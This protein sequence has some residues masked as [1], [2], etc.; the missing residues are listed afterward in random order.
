[1]VLGLTQFLAQ[2]T[3]VRKE[4]L[5]PLPAEWRRDEKDS[6]ASLLKLAQLAESQ[7]LQPNWTEVGGL[8]AV[9]GVPGDALRRL[10]ERVPA[11]AR[12]PYGLLH[13]DLGRDKVI[14]LD[15]AEP[16]VVCLDW[17]AAT[18]GD[19]LH[20]LVSHLVRMRYPQR[21]WGEVIRAWKQAMQRIRPMAVNGL[22]RDWRHYVDFERARAA[23][24]D[25]IDAAR[26]LESSLDE[27]RLQ[28]AAGAIR[29]ALR[30]AAAPL[31]LAQLPTEGEV[32]RALFRWQ[33]SRLAGR[34]GSPSVTAFQWV[35]DKRVAER[36]DFPPVLVRAALAAEGAAPADRVFK[37]TAHLNSV[38]S[39][40]GF[41]HP[42]VVRRK[43][44]AVPRRERGFLSE[45]AVL[46]VIEDSDLGVRAPKVLALGGDELGC[47]FAIHT[48][49][50]PSDRPPNHPV[51]GLL[52]HEADQLVDQLAALAR[53]NYLS[54]DPAGG[55]S[56]FY[57]WL[58]KRLVRLVDD[59]PAVSK[60]QARLQG[61]PDGPLLRKIL[62]RYRVAERTP[63][64]LH[65]DLNPWNLVR[66][67]RGT[68]LAII[69]WEMAM[70]GD[71]LY[72]LVRHLHLTPTRAGIRH[73]IF[74]RWKQK[75]PEGY[76]AGWENDWQ[77]YRWMEQVRS[78]YVDLDRL[79]TGAALD[80][81]NVR[82]ALDAYA[83]TLA[84]A[85]GSLGL[86]TR[87]T[88]APAPPDV[89]PLTRA[90]LTPPTPPSPPPPAPQ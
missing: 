83:M 60:D 53:V 68:G 13:T 15:T 75:L 49:E 80:T 25:V 19:P 77:V 30:D 20:G 45:H 17:K 27:Q 35:R 72:D 47:Q 71:P 6:R 76:V 88:P 56:D 16:S 4:T 10:A 85:T 46:K 26:S 69:D 32:E 48:Y 79:V 12:R 39:V 21:Q 44:V 67:G 66:D 22:A 42:V 54:L 73:R 11:M 29:R 57:G 14:V 9:L 3:Q 5:P 2:L 55:S 52:P 18:Y 37:G 7:L 58:S 65:G 36:A 51:H 59:L 84:A 78:A 8:F 86:R 34:G 87:P 41:P 28:K 43:T 63:V 90:G 89:L 31:G 62:G 1:V 81:P 50:G 74:E 70:I 33:A 24:T 64:L 61:L 40:N 38:V 23:Y 82:R